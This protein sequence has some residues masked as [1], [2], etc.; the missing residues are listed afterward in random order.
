METSK[1]DLTEIT[2]P[3]SKSILN[4]ALLLA[5]LKSSPT[6]L[7]CGA[8]CED[9]RT[10]L[11]CLRALGVKTEE[12]RGGIRVF[13]TAGNFQKKAE[14]DLKNAGTA[15]R[16]LPPVLAFCG[17]EYRFIASKQLARRPMD[18][19][20]ILK[21]LGAAVD[22]TKT[23]DG[24]L[25][26][27]VSSQ[28][29]AASEIS[30]GT[31]KSSQ[32]ASG[33]MLA[34][35]A[36]PRPVRILLTGKL[37]KSGYLSL[38]A[39][40]IEAFGFSCVKEA[41]G[42]TIFQGTG[43]TGK[44]ETAYSVEPDVSAA[45]YFAALSLLCRKK[46]KL[47]GVKC[48][49]KQSDFAFLQMLRKRG[50]ILKETKNGLIIDGTAVSSFK[51]F[52]EDFSGCSDQAV[53]AAVLAPFAETPSFIKNI[54]HIRYQECDRAEAIVKNLKKLGVPAEY[55]SGNLKILPATIKPCKIETFGDH[56]V[57][58]AFSVM[59]KFVEG[60]E[61]DDKDCVKKSFEGFFEAL[62]SIK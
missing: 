1:T 31:E 11:G 6:T 54:S 30:V 38:T 37:F 62:R 42:F 49:S 47:L 14:L 18:G 8:L 39:D 12:G 48:S 53:T 55:D 17:G 41:D 35:C 22:E 56:R 58:M 59:G 44:T 33:V 20:G 28:K 51:G 13:G 40:L 29:I 61:I 46:L 26:F 5:A 45:C 21:R 24:S 32:F 9:T 50:L 7:I 4:R 57:A 36:S 16:F 2:L 60:V 34:A 43:T 52:D 10:M 19:L 27:T 23:G 15:A 25:C 3:A